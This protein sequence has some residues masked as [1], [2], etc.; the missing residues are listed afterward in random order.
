[1]IFFGS[2]LYFLLLSSKAYWMNVEHNWILLTH[3]NSLERQWDICIREP[4]GSRSK[5]HKRDILLRFWSVPSR[6][7]QCDPSRN[8]LMAEIN[9]GKHFIVTILGTIYMWV[10]TLSER[11]TNVQR[12]EE[13]CTRCDT[14]V[15]AGHSRTTSDI[16]RMTWI[17]SKERYTGKVDGL[18]KVYDPSALDKPFRIA[19]RISI[20]KKETTLE[21]W[22]KRT[23]LSVSNTGFR[24]YTLQT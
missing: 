14:D 12:L 6:R 11:H 10:Q 13:S 22:T 15:L 4:F 5:W 18:T 3:R 1:M 24:V 7:S 17:S 21:N 8:L 19:M 2:I 23:I 16:W 9:E 20:V